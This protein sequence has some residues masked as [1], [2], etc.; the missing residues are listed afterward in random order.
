MN[1]KG[2]WQRQDVP[3]SKVALA[4]PLVPGAAL[5][6]VK[7]RTFLRLGDFD[8]WLEDTS[9]DWLANSKILA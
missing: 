6:D 4:D 1:E 9:V 3:S 5:E 7:A 2:S 8:E